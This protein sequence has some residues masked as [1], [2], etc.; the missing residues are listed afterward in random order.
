VRRNDK[1]MSVSDEVAA[2]GRE[3]R[4]LIGTEDLQDEAIINVFIDEDLARNVGSSPRSASE[5]RAFFADAPQQAPRTAEA[6][7]GA[8]AAFWKWA[9]TGF[10]VVDATMRARRLEACL[11]CEDYIDA[12]YESLYSVAAVVA[13]ETKICSQCGCFIDKKVRLSSEVCP[14]NAWPAK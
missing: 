9:G 14:R 5:L 1:R 11:Q 13:R 2:A 3:L 7:Y 6:I 4:R 8:A 10:R 12:P